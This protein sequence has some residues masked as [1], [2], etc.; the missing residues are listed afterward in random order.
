MR[1]SEAIIVWGS[2]L[3]VVAAMFATVYWP[4]INIRDE[5]SDIWRPL[6]SQEEKGRL[7]Y[8]ANGCTYC[9]SQYIRPQD[10]GI[11]AERISQ[12]GDYYRQIPHLLG[13]QRTGP[14]LSQ[15][16]G[17]H[18]DDW[19]RAHFINPRFTRPRSLMPAFAYIGEEGIES[20]IAY[21]Q[22]LGGKDADQRMAVQ[23]RFHEEAIAAWERGPDEHIRWLH[24]RVPQPWRIMPSETP[25]TRASVARGEKVYQDYCIGCHGPVGD[26]AGPAAP[27]IYPPPVNFTTLRR[28]LI[29]GQYIGGILYYQIMNGITGTAMPYHKKDL[30][31]A[32]IWDVG[33]YIMV[34]FINV[35][36]DRIPSAGIP[37]SY[38]GRHAKPVTKNPQPEP[39]QPG[40][41]GVR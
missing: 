25:A 20:L 30:E 41:G 35:R 24:S 22:S 15:E 40:K 4:V 7:I 23:N 37:V 29:D 1:S 39:I 2:L 21:I 13:S 12:S 32:K 31:S 8:I 18:S 14:D 3:V 26:G 36:D 38:E 10:W 5:P 6:Q 19:H 28:H 9:H 34:N 27:Y 17:E 33:N 11:G 16:G